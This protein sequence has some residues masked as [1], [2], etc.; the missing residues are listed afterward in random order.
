MKHDYSNMHPA[1]LF[2]VGIFGL[3]W[4]IFMIAYYLIGLIIQLIRLVFSLCRLALIAL[5]PSP[6]S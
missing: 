2:F 4:A 5:S 1:L 3:V 6:T